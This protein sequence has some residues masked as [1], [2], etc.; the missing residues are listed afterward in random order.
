MKYQSTPEEIR[1]MALEMIRDK[2]KELREYQFETL[3]AEHLSYVCG[4]L[5]GLM[6]ADVIS[7]GEYRR[8]ADEFTTGAV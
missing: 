6:W 2:L 5:S 3:I 7:H 1:S 4:T 8:R